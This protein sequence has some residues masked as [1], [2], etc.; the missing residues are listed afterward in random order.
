MPQMTT[1]IRP[2]KISVGVRPDAPERVVLML[3]DD[4]EG[5]HAI[6]ITLSQAEATIAA[7]QEEIARRRLMS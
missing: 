7:L 1:T 2:T 6:D 3:E 5:V 4:E